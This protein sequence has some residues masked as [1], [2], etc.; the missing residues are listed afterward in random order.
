MVLSFGSWFLA[1][2]NEQSSFDSRK[3]VIQGKNLVQAVANNAQHP[4]E[5]YNQQIKDITSG[6]LTKQVARASSRLYDEQQSEN[7][8]PAV[9]AGKDEQKDFE[10]KFLKIWG[11][12]EAIADL[13]P[14]TLGELYRGRYRDRIS[15]V[16]STLFQ[17]IE[18]RTEGPAA[19]SQFGRMPIR[20]WSHSSSATRRASQPPWT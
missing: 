10:E 9:F 13:P 7:P 19:A 4:S 20:K 1:I 6:P 2:N 11:P 16:F 15:E 8:L 14:G 5:A 3:K 17:L 18:R 12:M